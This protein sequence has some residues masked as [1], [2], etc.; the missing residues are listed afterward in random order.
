MGMKKTNKRHP[1]LFSCSTTPRGLRQ[2]LILGSVTSRGQR[3]KLILLKALIMIPAFARV[4]RITDHFATA[5]AH[6]VHAFRARSCL[7]FFGRDGRAKNDLTPS[8]PFGRAQLTSHPHFPSALGQGCAHITTMLVRFY[9]AVMGATAQYLQV[10]LTCVC[11]SGRGA[12]ISTLALR[13]SRL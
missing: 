10:Y 6:V 11:K 2:K 9:F 8:L 5:H 13:A 4:L 1:K 7:S 3:Q 12:Y